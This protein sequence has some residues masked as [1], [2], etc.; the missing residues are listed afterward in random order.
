MP[1]RPQGRDPNKHHGH[2]EKTTPPPEY[3]LAARFPDEPTSNTAYEATRQVL[4]D[5]PCDLSTYRTMLLPIQDWYVLVLGAMPD[6]QLRERIDQALQRGEAVELPE[7]V[8]RAFNQRRLEQ[9][10]KG[11]WTE[12]R[13]FGGRRL[14]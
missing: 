1:E 14:R 3:H 5:N 9:S 6:E 2:R 4:Y 10:S 11:L 12:K 13:H 8:W 7:E